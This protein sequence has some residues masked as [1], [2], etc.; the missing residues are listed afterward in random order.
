M[1]VPVAELPTLEEGQW[2]IEDLTFGSGTQFPIASFPDISYG[3]VDVQDKKRPRGDG[4]IFGRDRYNA[5]IITFDMA[6][7]AADLELNLQW[8]SKWWR[9]NQTRWMPN[10]AMSLKYCFEGKQRQVFGRPR[11]FSPIPGPPGREWVRVQ[12]DFQCID[13]K[14]YSQE[15]FHA[16]VDIDPSSLGG[17]YSPLIAPLQ[18]IGTS[19]STAGEFSSGGNTEAWI[20]AVIQGPIDFPSFE[21]IDNVEGWHQTMPRLS[22]NFDQHVV[23]SSYPW[24]RRIIDERGFSLGG[25]FDQASRKLSRLW[26]PPGDHELVLRGTDPTGTAYMDLYW[27]EAYLNI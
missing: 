11:N 12:C 17:L 9:G 26:L 1:T 8:L 7:W 15:E 21:L 27:Y 14:F 13:D 19:S 18:T 24:D 23:I 25:A 22:M 3:S 16:H 2:R 20:R 10:K 6:V 5:N 4:L